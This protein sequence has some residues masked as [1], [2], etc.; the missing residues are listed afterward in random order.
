[1]R[2]AIAAALAFVLAGCGKQL[3]KPT[4]PERCPAISDPGTTYD[5]L[6]VWAG[7]MIDAYNACAV[8]VDALHD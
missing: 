5:E 7:R 4:A 1:M 3:V 2:I 8:K 6:E